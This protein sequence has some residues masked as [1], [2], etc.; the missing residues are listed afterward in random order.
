MKFVSYERLIKDV[1]NWSSSLPLDY[2]VIV[3]VPRSGMLPASVLAL[4]RNVALADIHTFAHGGTFEGGFR[5]QHQKRSKA[6]VL[7][8]SILSGRSMEAARKKLADV[9]DW[10]IDYAAVYSNNGHSNWVRSFRC[11]PIPRIFEWNM[12]HSYWAKQ[13]CVDIDGVLCRDPTV[14]ENDDGPI[15]LNFLRTVAPRHR[16]T[17]QLHTLCT[18]RLEKYRSATV[19][20]LS[21]HGIVYENLVMHP[22]RSK[23]E[24]MQLRDHAIRK[25]EHYHRSPCKVFIESSD[26]QAK[27]IYKISGKPVICTDTMVIYA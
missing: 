17:V 26:W 23:E 15:Y 22:A 12:F 25:A 14:A 20:W 2:D 5:D 27:E 19:D 1:V 4:H 24:R 10:E 3:G 7:D 11:L 16:A 21:R 13:A 9:K 18:G 8:D 6:L